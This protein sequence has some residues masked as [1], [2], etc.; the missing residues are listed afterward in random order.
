MQ[1]FE[2]LVFHGKLEARSIDADASSIRLAKGSRWVVDL[3]T[4]TSDMR[5]I[6]LA[7][8]P[9]SLLDMEDGSRLVIQS[10][11]ENREPVQTGKIVLAHSDGGRI[12]LG[13]Q[14]EVRKPD[15]LGNLQI[16]NGDLV[17]QVKE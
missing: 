12:T 8:R 9:G 17:I 1:A 5:P 11:A 13:N 16:E 3:E 6:F 14:M 7:V 15:W 2:S 10:Q 4:A